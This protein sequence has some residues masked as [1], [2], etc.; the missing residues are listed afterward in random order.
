MAEGMAWSASKEAGF[1]LAALLAED[2]ELLHV[3]PALE[4]ACA[5]RLCALRTTDTD[6]LRMVR[7]LL[8]RLRP[9][10]DARA[11]QLPPRA[12]ALLARVAPGELRKQLLRDS[13]PT[14]AHFSAD[15]ELIAMLVRVARKQA[16]SET[17]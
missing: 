17:A 11:L 10:L 9:P 13:K 6:R 16:G 14:R 5:E 12:R 4:P 1:M 2:R 7:A 3:A 8:E 15:E